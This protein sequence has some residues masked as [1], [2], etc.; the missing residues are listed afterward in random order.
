MPAHL[1][2]VEQA[3]AYSIL[4]QPHKAASPINGVQHP[5]AALHTQRGPVC[6]VA[7]TS[8][9]VLTHNRPQSQP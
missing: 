9:T 1:A 4:A 6:L 8:G 2:L 5:M 3:Q 7:Q